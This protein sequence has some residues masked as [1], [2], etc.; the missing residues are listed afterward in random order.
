M[1]SQLPQAFIFIRVGKHAG[2]DFESILERKQREL[3]HAGKIFWVMA[4]RHYTQ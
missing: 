4:V 3:E 1:E 2:E